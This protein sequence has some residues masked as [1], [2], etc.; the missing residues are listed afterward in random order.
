MTGGTQQPFP[1]ELSVCTQGSLE[2][3]SSDPPHA[4]LLQPSASHHHVSPQSPGFC[5]MRV[6][7][8][9]K[10]KKHLKGK[11]ELAIMSLLLIHKQPPVKPGARFSDTEE[12][13]IQFEM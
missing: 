9:V 4:L 2:A 10:A 8:N 5:F 11:A 13:E 7:Q 3:R 1:G 12:V 6:I